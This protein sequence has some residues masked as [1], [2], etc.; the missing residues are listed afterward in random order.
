[1]SFSRLSSHTLWPHGGLFL[2]AACCLL[3]GPSVVRGSEVLQPGVL[4]ERTIKRDE[5][6]EYLVSLSSGDFLRVTLDQRG[7]DVEMRLFAPDGTEVA[8]VDGPGPYNTYAIEDLAAVAETSGLYRL[9]VLVGGKLA[10]GATYQ[11]RMETPRPAQPEDLLRVEAVRANQA[12]TLA[13]GNRV[14]QE[15]AYREK[16]LRLWREL[17]ERRREADTMLLLGLLRQKQGETKEASDLFHDAAKL[18]EEAGDPA[19]QARALNEAARYCEQIGHTD[20]AL[21]EY[22]QSVELARQAG[23]RHSETFALSNLGVLLNRLGRSQEAVQHLSEALRIA[24]ELGWQDL[25]GNRLVNLGSAYQDLS[26]I[27]TAISLYQEALGLSTEQATAYNNLGDAYGALGDWDAAIESY[28]RALDFVQNPSWKAATL[29]NLALAYHKSGQHE[30]ARRNYD[31]ALNLA[32]AEEH[33]IVQILAS[34]NLGFLYKEMGQMT[35]AL[36][37]WRKVPGLAEGREDLEH[38]ALNAQASVLRAEGKIEEARAMLE[39]TREAA[40]RRGKTAWEAQATLTLAS[41]EKDRGKLTTALNHIKSA[42]EIIETLRNRVLDPD[43][44]ALF[45]ASKQTY[46]EHHIDILMALH[47]SHPGEGYDARA[48]HAS[49]QAR[50]RGLLDL[51]TEAGA[52]IREGVDRSLLEK[53][54]KLREEIRNRDRHWIALIQEKK[55]PEQIDEAERLLQDALDDLDQFE[56][57]LRQS[58]ARYAA[59][60]H[61]EPL[62]V[63]DIQRRV[64]GEKTLLLEYALGETKS[65]LWA[66]TPTSLQSFELKGRKEIEKEALAYYNAVTAR[67]DLT[68]GDSPAQADAEAERAGRALSD[69]ILKDVAPLLGDRTLLVVA[70]GALQYVP[71]AALPLPSAPL[72]PLVTRN[73]VVTLPSASTLAVLRDELKGRTPA[74]KVLAVLADPVFTKEDS[75]VT[76]NAR[77]AAK[78]EGKRGSVNPGSKGSQ[79]LKFERLIFSKE[80]ADGIA[81]LVRPQDQVLKA[82][83]FEAS[84]A[85]ATSGELAR[86][87]YVHFA[88]HGVLDSSQPELSRLVL[89]QVDEKGRSQEGFL[90]LQDIYNLRLNADMVVL[91]ACQTA[92]GKELRGEGLVGLTR[93]FMYAGSPRVVASL[94]SVEDRATATLMKRFYRYLLS[95]DMP[96]ATA[97]R[98]AQLDLASKPQFKSPYYWAGFSLQGE[99]K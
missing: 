14:D 49:E 85:K 11:L 22:R 40:R 77:V 75:R 24:R 16:A 20:Y 46:Y 31:E 30:E 70:D 7:V 52:D 80:E 63:A 3:L 81:S 51:L 23:D 35:D 17:G 93:G 74:P 88:T 65:Y 9:R 29:N 41:L 28:R 47:R 98:K 96:A 68:K 91:S 33:L 53:E 26:E 56:V 67:N 5:P 36:E 25:V 1:M 19:G 87:R 78:P 21:Q 89:S 45:L 62:N 59:L 32:R 2:L 44:R 43:L 4:V 54:Q 72:Q 27:Q 18:Y 10:P 60:T 57:E 61:P 39:S 50:A 8:L 66:V 12:A 58:S 15:L 42:I 34:N 69:L 83:D 73:E 95:E 38:V 84:F 37:S 94:W 64:L 99:W 13:T 76:R 79:D 86:Y 82:L 97:L 6:H 48:L 55:S 92:L 71:F 90:R